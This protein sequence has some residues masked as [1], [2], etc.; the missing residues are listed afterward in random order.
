MH[1]TCSYNAIGNRSLDLY[2]QIAK[3][4]LLT[5]GPRTA[6]VHLDFRQLHRFSV[7]LREYFVPNGYA[8]HVPGGD[9]NLAD[10]YSGP[11]SS[12]GEGFE[13]F[14]EG[15]PSAQGT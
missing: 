5:Q 12:R 8:V 3:G 9:Q 10:L 7:W 4:A 1:L 2:L 13:D 11:F 15:C 14:V 6:R